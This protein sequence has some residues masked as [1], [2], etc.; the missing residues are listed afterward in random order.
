MQM[1]KI[2]YV[3]V[4]PEYVTTMYKVLGLLHFLNPETHRIDMI[5]VP[6]WTKYGE[7]WGMHLV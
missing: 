6:I 7:S 1:E 3:V 4:T 5:T 2:T